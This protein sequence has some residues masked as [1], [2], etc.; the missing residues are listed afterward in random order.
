MKLRLL[1]LMLPTLFLLNFTTA[2]YAGVEPSPFISEINQLEAVVNGLNSCLDRVQKIIANPPN[3]LLPSPDMNGAINRL[4]AIAGQGNSLND[5]VAN[6]I[7]SVMGVEPSPFKTDLIPAL[8]SVGNVSQAIVNVIVD[9]V[10]H[11]PDPGYEIPESFGF[12]LENVMFSA[13]YLRETVEDG[14]IQIRSEECVFT[15]LDE[16]ACM[17]NVSC[18]W[19]S[20]VLSFCC[21]SNI[22]LN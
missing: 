20:D 3:A 22:I 12:A 6:T 16:F 1:F 9:F 7:L 11:P 5:F 17:E 2:L 21:C 4:E 8:E 14:I 13:M 10:E 15:E 18:S 19:V